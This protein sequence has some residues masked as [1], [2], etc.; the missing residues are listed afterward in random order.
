MKKTHKK[1]LTYAAIGASAI[2]LF[3]YL[4]QTMKKPKEDDK[5]NS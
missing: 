2:G 1:I 5:K 3:Y 4:S